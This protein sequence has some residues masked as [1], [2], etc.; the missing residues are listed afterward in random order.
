VRWPA[1]RRACDGFV[2]WEHL[3]ALTFFV[4]FLLRK[5][6]QRD[7]EEQSSKKQIACL[8]ERNLDVTF[9]MIDGTRS[10][11]GNLQPLSV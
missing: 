2:Q 11:T 1:E 4:L 9:R 10:R 3:S 7:E 5:K 6:G 8:K